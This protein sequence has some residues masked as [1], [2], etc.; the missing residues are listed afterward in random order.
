MWFESTVQ[1]GGEPVVLAAQLPELESTVQGELFPALSAEQP[2]FENTEQVGGPL[3]PLLL[4][5][6]WL[7]T[8]QPPLESTVQLG[9]EPELLIEQLWLVASTA[10]VVGEPVGVLTAHPPL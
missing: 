4:D 9:D 8:E 1:A 3:L 5:G 6:H 10:Q 7:L 2:W